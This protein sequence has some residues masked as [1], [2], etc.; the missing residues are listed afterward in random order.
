MA[1]HPPVR[2][3][4]RPARVRRRPHARDGQGIA[5]LWRAGGKERGVAER[6]YKYDK[7]RIGTH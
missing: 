3:R 7:R 4:T 6:I 5:G 2:H 1:A